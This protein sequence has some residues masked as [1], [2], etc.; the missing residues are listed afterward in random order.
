MLDINKVV[1]DTIANMDH[2]GKI[3]ELIEAKVTS[4]IE[5]IMEDSFKEYS[6]FGKGLK[7]YIDDKLNIDFDGIGL[8]GYHDH[9]I[10]M[11][12][13]IMSKQLH[14]ESEAKLKKTL[15]SMLVEA[16]KQIKLSDIIKQAKGQFTE[17]ASESDNRWGN[18]T[19]RVEDRHDNFFRRINIDQKPDASRYQCNYQIGLSKQHREDEN[20][21]RTGEVYWEVFT[22]TI[23]DTNLKN[24]LFVGPFYNIEK[25]LYQLHCANSEI[26]IDLEDDEIHEAC[27]YELTDEDDEYY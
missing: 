25:L 1:Q 7:T 11:I 8:E 10:K 4:T 19:C 18:M 26:I 22:M 2:E 27:E 16:P 20:G 17:E 6:S 14:G 15:E 24:N 9:I 23:N 21:N 13:T 5:S 3:Q 12:S